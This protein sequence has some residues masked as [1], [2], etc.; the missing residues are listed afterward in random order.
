MNSGPLSM[1]ICLRIPAPACQPLEHS[2]HALPRQGCIDLNCQC[3]AVVVVDE[4]QRPQA[5]PPQQGVIHEIHRP[6]LVGL[7]RR[8]QNFREAFGQSSSFVNPQVQ[9]HGTVYPVDPFMVPAMPP[10]TQPAKQFVE[11]PT[12]LGFR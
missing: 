1:R 8:L 3:L 7:F 6:T 12:R 4:V 10:I 11:A 9:F 2:H 5:L